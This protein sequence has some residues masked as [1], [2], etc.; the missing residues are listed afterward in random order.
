MAK[1]LLVGTLFFN[2]S[3]YLDPGGD[4]PMS[5]E[6]K[7]AESE[8]A[9]ADAN[10]RA[11][12]LIGVP[13][14]DIDMRHDGFDVVARQLIE[15]ARDFDPELGRKAYQL[16]LEMHTRGAPL[17]EHMQL[18]SITWEMKRPDAVL[19]ASVMIMACQWDFLLNGARADRSICEEGHHRGTARELAKYILR[20]FK[21]DDETQT[22]LDAINALEPRLPTSDLDDIDEDLDDEDEDEDEDLD[23]GGC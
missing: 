13:D 12:S 14:E 21:R 2:G 11:V 7:M 6:S 19:A 23:D 22:A 10:D 9:E 15:Q 4:R 3:V 8:M 1:E 16:L 20:T 18:P 17:P 5:D